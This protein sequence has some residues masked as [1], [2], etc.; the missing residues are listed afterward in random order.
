MICLR[1]EAYKLQILEL[2]TVKN[3][4]SATTSKGTYTVVLC[5]QTTNVG[6]TNTICLNGFTSMFLFRKWTFKMKNENSEKKEEMKNEKKI[7][8]LN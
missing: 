3:T 8:F 4:D 5:R 7:N 6:H 1:C 2:L